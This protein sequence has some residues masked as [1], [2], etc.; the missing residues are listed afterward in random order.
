MS[1]KAQEFLQS[2][3]AMEVPKELPSEFID[4]YLERA[5]ILEFDGRL[6]RKDAGVQA[7]DEIFQR[8]MWHTR[9]LERTRL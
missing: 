8:I 6:S 1:F 7:L 3:F 5:A 2:L 4:D 9:E